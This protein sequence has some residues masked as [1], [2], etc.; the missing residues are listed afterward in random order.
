M[1]AF[2][3]WSP[4]KKAWLAAGVAAASIGLLGSQVARWLALTTPPVVVG[5]P[6]RS[7]TPPLIASAVSRPETYSN[8]YKYDYVGPETCGACHEKNYA[9]WKNHPHSRM[10]RNASAG[11][12]VGDFAD[13]RIDYGGGHATFSK[14]Q[15]EYLMTIFD[16]A[17]AVRRFKVTRVVGSR[18]IQMYI[19]VETDGPEPAGDPVYTEE[20][21]LPFS[22]WIDRKEWFPQTYDED[23]DGIEYDEKKNLTPAYDYRGKASGRWRH[24]CIKC[25]N[26]YPY[27]LRFDP[28]AKG[29]F[30]GFPAADIALKAKPLGLHAEST[31]L[32]DVDPSELVTLGISCESC[33]FGGR[34]H[35]QKGASV[36]FLPKSDDLTLA[37]SAEG[38]GESPYAVNSI[39]HQCHAAEPQGP[40]YPDGSASWNAREA[41][42]LVESACKKKIS[43]IDCHNP[44]EAGPDKPNAPDNPAHVDACLGCHSELR[45]PEAQ[46]AH[47]H[48]AKGDGVGCL[49]CHMPRIVHGLA[50]FT[51]THRISSPTDPRMLRADE[52]N[53]C[54]LCHLDKSLKWTL[55]ALSSKWGKKPDMGA[56][57]VASDEPLGKVWL[58]H[59]EPVVRHVAAAAYGRS[60]MGAAALPFILPLLD[61][62]SP[63]V[64]MFSV[65][66]VEDALDRRIGTDEY[67][68]WAPPDVREKQME[69]LSRAAA[70]AR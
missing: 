30:L 56:G 22:Y 44:H 35:A 69:A 3:S 29:I 51:R 13:A 55:D 68:P 16:G 25:H 70:D 48:H 36:S 62:P 46:L 4:R 27:A 17:E 37:V 43:C 42:D 66:A 63:P 32:S 52:P 47:G 34:E 57:F 28:G 58:K 21:K 24:V 41:A 10:N 8:I 9:K 45:A 54:N 40:L 61:D 19:G 33:H 26:T 12:V 23:V 15:G 14:G 39:C 67:T 60:S 65:L 18:F 7:A 49:D 53:A 31:G 59:K 64:R 38:T 11:S 5:A 6:A 1:T 20:V 50:G 2:S